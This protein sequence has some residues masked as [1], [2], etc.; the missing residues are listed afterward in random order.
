[1]SDKVLLV[2]GASRGIGRSIALLAA[3]DGWAVGVNYASDRGSA[4]GVVAEIEAA[5]GR[6][7]AVQSDVSKEA[8]VIALFDAVAKALGPLRGF[9]GNAGINLPRADLVDMTAERMARIV[10][11]NLLG[12]Y[13]CNREAA[14]MMSTVKG[15]Q[16]GSIVNISSVAA[17]LGSPNE[18]VDYAGTKG[19]IDTMT[20]GLC[21]ELGPVGIRVNAIRPGLIET[22]IHVAAGDPDRVARASASIPLGRA[23]RPDEVAEAA[24][25]LLSEKASYVSGAI[26][27]VG[28]GR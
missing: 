9:V 2:T 5:G 19:G 12:A 21:K 23:G 14:R 24:V 8:E 27:D 10:E 22:D 17:R 7:V 26:L 28:G 13:L 1:M 11:V 3:K 25:W 16:G 4:E 18:Y 20:L 15:G 6:A